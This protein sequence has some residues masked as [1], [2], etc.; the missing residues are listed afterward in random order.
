LPGGTALGAGKD[1]ASGAPD[2]VA[3]A[4]GG[5]G[6]AKVVM[7]RA[8][9]GGSGCGGL[10]RG[11]LPDGGICLQALA[12]VHGRP[13]R[14]TFSIRGDR[15]AGPRQRGDRLGPPAAG[16]VEGVGDIS[17]PVSRTAATSEEVP[18]VESG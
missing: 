14:R 11:G 18:I 1:G 15:Q 13:N 6:V 3:A 5:E 10:L 12:G 9:D 8:W 4:A 7:R 2:E 17:A 16:R